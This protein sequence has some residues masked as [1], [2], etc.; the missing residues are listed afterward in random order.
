MLAFLLTSLLLL[1][2]LLLLRFLSP[3]ISPKDQP[4]FTSFSPLIHSM[5]LT[6]EAADTLR[7]EASISALLSLLLVA[8]KEEEE[9]EEEEIALCGFVVDTIRTLLSLLTTIGTVL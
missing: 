5:A 2:L 8:E 4:L 7:K 9:E 6:A 1:L 3:T